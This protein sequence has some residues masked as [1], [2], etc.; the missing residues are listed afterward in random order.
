VQRYFL[1][2]KIYAH[3]FCVIFLHMKNLTDSCKTKSEARH[4]KEDSMISNE[5]YGKRGRKSKN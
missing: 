2:F 3:V 4:V 1:P 5:C